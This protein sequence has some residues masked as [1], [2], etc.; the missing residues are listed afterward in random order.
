MSLVLRAMHDAAE[1]QAVQQLSSRRVSR[2]WGPTSPAWAGVQVWT[3]EQQALSGVSHLFRRLCFMCTGSNS[4]TLVCAGGS[5][6]RRVED[7][8]AQLLLQEQGHRGAGS[9]TKLQPYTPHTNVQDQVR[10]VLT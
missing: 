9:H 7:S 10:G 4:S 8:G 1:A 2:C 6:I 5:G 3:E